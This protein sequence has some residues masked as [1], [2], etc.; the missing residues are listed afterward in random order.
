LRRHPIYVVCDDI[1]SL[2]NVGSIFR[3]CD[4]A[5]VERLYLCGITGY[6]P[7]AN[8]ARPPW[9]AERAGRLIAKTALHT[10]SYVP[11]EHNS[12]GSDVVADLKRRG[13]QIV[14]LE[15]TTASVDFRQVDY[16][17]PVAVILGHERQG[18]GTTALDLADVIAEIPMWGEG[19]SLNVAVAFGIG[20]YEI[21]RRVI[22]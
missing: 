9:A 13:V 17:F 20:I 18:V 15:R 14:A 1:R 6:P 10:V 3:L 19:R 8:D 22:R 16:R 2:L 7:T 11:W 5:R 12:S 4:A 21:L